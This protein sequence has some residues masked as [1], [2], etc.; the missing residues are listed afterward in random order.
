MS[1]SRIDWLFVSA[2]RSLLWPFSINWVHFS[3]VLYRKI[4]LPFFLSVCSFSRSIIIPPPVEIMCSS[5]WPTSSTILR[6][7]SRKCFQPFCWTISVIEAFSRVFIMLSVSISFHS[8]N[9]AN[10]FA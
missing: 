7:R 10:C 5:S 9:L 4:I 3:I 6:S 2:G 8:K 1:S